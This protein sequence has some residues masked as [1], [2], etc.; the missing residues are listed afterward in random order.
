MR[1]LL[2][3]A[4]LLSGLP[5]LAQGPKPPR[6]GYLYPAGIQRG[7]SAEI[8]V[9][10]QYIEGAAEVICTGS[11]LVAKVART[12]KPLV[13]K[14]ENEL[15]DY[16]Q[17]A[18]K[19]AMEANEA[20]ARMGRFEKPEII[21]E[22]LK[23]AGAT[24]DEIRLFLLQRKRRNDPK[25]QQ[26]VQ[27]S[28][29]AYLQVD[30]APDAAPGPRELRLRGTAGISNPLTFCV[31]TFPETLKSEAAGKK[32]TDAPRVTLPAVINGQIPPGGV[33]H[34]AFTAPAGARLVVALQGR[35]LI[36][37]LADAVP[38]WFQPVVALYDAAGREAAFSGA[39]R[40]NPDPVFCYDVPK[41]GTYY[42][43]IRDA[44]YRGRE[45]FVYRVRVGAFPFVTGI[46]PLG[47]PVGSAAAVDVSGWNLDTARRIIAPSK[48]AGSFHPANLSNGLSVSDVTFAADTLPEVTETE[49]ND[50]LKTAQLVTPPLIVNGRIDKPGDIDQ[51]RF[52]CKAGET[53]VADVAARR[54]NSPLDSWLRLTDAEGRQLAFNDDRE[55]LAAGLLTHQ[56]DSAFAFPIPAD[57]VYSLQIGDTQHKGGPEYAYR[58][59]IGPPRPDFALRWVPS[60]V[61]GKP[62]SSVPVT[63]YAMR[64]DGFSG[65]IALSLKN[66]PPGFRLDG[67]TIPAGMTKVQASVTLPPEPLDAPAYLFA[68]GRATVG[69]TAVFRPVVPSDDL[70]QAFA[71]HH[72]VPS[73]TLVAMT[74][75]TAKMQSF[76]FL[77]NEPVV[78]KPG[79][80]GRVVLKRM[81]R[82]PQA[83]ELRLQPLEAVEGIGV[84]EIAAVPE[85]LAV[86]LTAAPEAKPG[87]AG[88]LMFEAFVERTPPGADKPKKWSIGALPAIPFRVEAK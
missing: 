2:M 63:I 6:I 26:N 57:G 5:A 46:F 34:Y 53:L 60:A 25:R 66:T 69:G 56:A 82:L 86:T 3:I 72:L 14:R 79:G 31:G 40:F 9:G 38:G 20:P 52:S 29:T 15:R 81:G 59:R 12:E 88:N 8:A 21:A 65:D 68:E 80:T 45:D 28:E 73:Q 35:D 42:L 47:G 54:L 78:L 55:D 17:D 87:L 1:R 49:P 41:P 37:Y 13:G 16:I 48:E 50:T 67:A 64:R 7:T 18:R 10:G 71:Y 44:L 70:L 75:G 83:S 33:D 43:E 24:E 22:I 62:G 32:L 30:A 76:A 36:P 58:L 74:T 11:G 51:Y 23:E 77:S 84:G 4:L 19:K 27:L 39:F 61:N 85:G